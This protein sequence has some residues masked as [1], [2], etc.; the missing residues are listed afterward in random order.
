MEWELILTVSSGFFSVVLTEAV[1][2]IIL[3]PSYVVVTELSQ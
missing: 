3:I 2:I 1:T